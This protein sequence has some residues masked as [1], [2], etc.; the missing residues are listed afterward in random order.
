MT[1]VATQTKPNKQ[2]ERTKQ[3]KETIASW[4][5]IAGITVNGENPWDIQVHDD[6]FY[7]RV[8]A[9]GSLGLGES[10]MDGWW[11]AVKLDELICHVLRANL[12]KKVA[13]NLKI[14]MQALSAKVINLQSRERSKKV[15]EV[16]YNLDNNLYRKMLGESMAYTCG[17][18][19][20]ADNLDQ[21]QYAKYELICRKLELQPGER[22][23]ELGCGWGGF[24]K[25]AAEKYGVTMMSVNI[26]K[27]Q[28]AYGRKLCEGLPV[29]FCLCDY[30]D[31][32]VYNPQKESFDKV[33]SIG[34][35]EH[36]GHKNYKTFMRIAHNNLKEGGLFLLHT[37][38]ANDVRNTIEPWHGKYIFPNGCLPAAQQLATAAENL[39]LMEDWHNFGADYDKTLMAWFENFESHWEELKANYDERFYRMWVYYLKSCAGMFRARDAGLWQLVYSKGRRVGG[40]TSVR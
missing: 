18:W 5:K 11:D 32:Y 13:R 30:R 12:D 39:F 37:I 1:E 29:T 16:H 21:A 35:C 20:E 38:G 40:Y 9:E 6:R 2:L 15:A 10:Y 7:S 3:A 33:V 28:V 17:Y 27:E 8:L 14:I 34:M 19:K 31:D 4:L 26:A 24:A 22:V 25:Y 36:V 23:L